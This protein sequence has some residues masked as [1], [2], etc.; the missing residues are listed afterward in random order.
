MHPGWV[1]SR[2]GGSVMKRINQKMAALCW[3]DEWK[4]TD[5]DLTVYLPESEIG[6]DG[7]NEHFLVVE[8]PYEGHLLAI[9]TQGN[10]EGGDMQRVVVARSEDDGVTWSQPQVID[11]AH[12]DD[13]LIASWGFPVVSKSGRIY[14]FYNKHTGVVDHHRTTTGVMKCK[15]SDDDGYTWADGGIIPFGRSDRDNLNSEIPP[16][17]IVW[18]KTIR[19]S[20]NRQI[21]GFTRHTSKKV[22]PLPFGPW[23]EDSQSEFIRFDNIDEGPDP[24]EL[25]IT[26]L[27]IKGKAIRIS[28][29]GRPEVSVAQEPSLVLLPDNRLFLCFSDC[30]RSNLV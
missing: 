25:K 20:K 27:P 9:W 11:S 19:D 30:N 8:T 24:S 6:D 22:R 4:R 12:D 23:Q 28:L 3:S 29:P 2:Y 16:N 18:Q 15:Y 17:W 13:G 7:D 10:A 14:C 5:P 21:V 1:F 26:W